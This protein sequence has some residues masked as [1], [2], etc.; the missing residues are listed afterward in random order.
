[1]KTTSKAG[2]L[3]TVAITAIITIAVI[4]GALWALQNRFIYREVEQIAATPKGWDAVSFDVPG[5]GLGVAHHVA[6]QPGKPTLL[7]LQGYGLTGAVAGS[8]GF[9]ASGMGVLAPEYPGHGGAEGS[10]S[11]ATLD[12]TADA[13]MAW[14]RAKGV[15]PSDI[16]VYGIGVGAGPAIHAALQPNR[17]LV[18]VSG[19]A[20]MSDT[21]RS[22]LPILPD[23]MVSDD[24]DNVEAIRGVRG[25]VTIVHGSADQEVP[26]E[27]G[28]RLARASRTS[29]ITLPGDH[30]IAFDTG[31]QSA[32]A[33]SLS[34]QPGAAPA[35]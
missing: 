9:V 3:R 18:V 8:K 6:A 1:M 35:K 11:Q 30:M 33:G 5:V 28:E 25:R 13:A 26:F 7:L 15:A 16:V 23:F 24:W 34:K 12:A 31:L 27:Q 20:D 21:V 10:P 32:L 17:R 2:T 4:I 22:H 19:V 14:L 29:V